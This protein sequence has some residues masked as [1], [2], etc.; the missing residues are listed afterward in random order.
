MLTCL[1]CPY[2]QYAPTRGGLI[3]M[4]H[5]SIAFFNNITKITTL[6]ELIPYLQIIKIANKPLILIDS[7]VHANT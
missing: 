1:R 3:T 2:I 5:E 4:I 6:V 7:L